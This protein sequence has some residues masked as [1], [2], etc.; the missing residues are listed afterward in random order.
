MAQGIFWELRASKTS[1][2]SAKGSEIRPPPHRYHNYL[3]TNG[4]L[5]NLNGPQYPWAQNTRLERAL[6]LLLCQESM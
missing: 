1:K 4:G 2:V 3:T 6:G 5:Q